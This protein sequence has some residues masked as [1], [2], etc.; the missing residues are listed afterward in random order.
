MDEQT[1][2]IQ[3]EMSWCMLFAHS[4]MLIDETNEGINQKVE[5]WKSTL[6]SKNLG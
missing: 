1:N 5:L 3:D 2:T 6:E 4:I